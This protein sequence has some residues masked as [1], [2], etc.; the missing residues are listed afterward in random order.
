MVVPAGAATC[1]YAWGTPCIATANTDRSQLGSL[2]G[3]AVHCLADPHLVMPLLGKL[4]PDVEP[5]VIAVFARPGHRHERRAIERE[6]FQPSAPKVTVGSGR[7]FE[8]QCRV[9]RVGMPSR[10]GR[11]GEAPA[12]FRVAR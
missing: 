7:A 2:G 12:A 9:A 3:G 5:C 8:D 4:A 1:R 10:S 11:R 6:P